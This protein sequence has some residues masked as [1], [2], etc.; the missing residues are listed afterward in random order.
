MRLWVRAAASPVVGLGHLL[1]QVAV[2][3]R[4]AARGGAATFVVDDPTLA[5]AALRRFDALGADL[6]RSTDP[7][8]DRVAAE[9][10]VVFDGYGLGVDDHRAARARGCAVVAVDDRGSGRFDVDL[11]CDHNPLAVAYDL[12]AG[13]VLL[14]GL[15]YA[16]VRQEF[17]QGRSPGP[18]DDQHLLVAFGGT[19]AAGL[20][21][22]TLEALTERTRFPRVTV[23]LGPGST[24][25]D[26]LPAG[27][28]AVVAPA[29]VAAVHAGADAA[30][31][32]VGTTLWELLLRGTPTAAIGLDPLHRR[33]IEAVAAEGAVV[34]AG[35]ADEWLAALPTTLDRLADP[36]TRRRL[37]ENA[38]RLVDGRGPDRVV[39][40]LWAL[41][42]LS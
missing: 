7:W 23:L 22:R 41:R 20:L 13:A 36:A 10:V 8:L 34:D 31:I 6:V 25:P 27:V 21:P 15:R 28:S 33:A 24:A 39:D 9:D 40:A 38:C 3:E 19:D 16:L 26:H 2:V 1:R 30:L 35:P 18:A 11:L 29:D 17:R 12:P 32:T 37:G 42:P 14:H 5:G 4:V